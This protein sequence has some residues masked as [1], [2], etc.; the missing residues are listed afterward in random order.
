MSISWVPI[1]QLAI[2]ALSAWP[3]L[4]LSF[5]SV[6]LLFIT[7]GIAQ[8]TVTTV[9]ASELPHS[10]S[11]YGPPTTPFTYAPACSDHWR[12]YSQAGTETEQIT[13][14]LPLSCYPSSK[15]NAP[16]RPIYS[17][18]SCISGHHMLAIQEA[19]TSRY[20]KG[21]GRLWLGACCRR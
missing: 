3:N 4:P 6:V 15:M 16:S 5:H 13:N 14:D 2:S 19:R 17:P 12:Q 11:L 1:L 20:N 8:T 21:D 9:T 18:G 10:L 7:V